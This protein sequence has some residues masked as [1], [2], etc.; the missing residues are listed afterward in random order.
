[1]QNKKYNIQHGDVSFHIV[2]GL[3]EGVKEINHNGVFVVREGELTGHQHR[4]KGKFKLFQD[5]R[6]NYYV[7]TQNAVIEHYNR[8]TQ[9][10]AEHQELVFSPNT[11]YKI[12]FEERY[13]P[14]L[15]ALEKVKD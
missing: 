5:E 8:L 15:E 7:L 1:M 10:P 12:E 4:V 11:I 6:G 3:P 14:F 2:D 9:K 13:N